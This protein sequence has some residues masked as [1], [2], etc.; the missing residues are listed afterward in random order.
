MNT[1]E[2]TTPEVE[3]SAEPIFEYVKDRHNQKVGVI[4]AV[5]IGDK[6]MISHSRA[7]TSRGDKFDRKRGLDIAIDR[8]IKLSTSY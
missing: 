3:F 2:Q 6:V 7:N 4:A 8:A 1:T 5:K